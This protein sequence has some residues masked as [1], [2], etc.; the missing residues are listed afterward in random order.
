MTDRCTETCL[1]P[2]Y[3]PMFSCFLKYPFPKR[4]SQRE[5]KI[6]DFVSGLDVSE[7][8]GP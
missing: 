8:A 1:K 3:E 6:K 2:Y 5:R 4:K 7:N